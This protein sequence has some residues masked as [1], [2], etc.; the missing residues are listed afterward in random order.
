MNEI[1]QNDEINKRI[2][3]TKSHMLCLV[4]KTFGNSLRNRIKNVNPN[5]TLKKKLKL[6][7]K[8]KGSLAR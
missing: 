2:I 3:K 8:D 1:D 5:M 4:S 6:L 7:R